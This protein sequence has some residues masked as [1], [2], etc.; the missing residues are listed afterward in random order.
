[1]RVLVTRPEI[2]ARQ[3]A[4]KLQALGH[5]PALLPLARA[6]HNADVA[7]TALSRPHSA[8]AITSAEAVRVLKNLEEQL[9][10][11]LHET[12]YAVGD[13]TAKAAVAAGFRNV[14]AG[15]GTG[16]DLATQIDAPA[17]APLL[18]LAGK[19]RSTG[20][21]EGLHQRQLPF[22]IAE[23]YEMVPIT[24]DTDTVSRSLLEPPVDAVLLYS[25][26]SA[27]RFFDVAAPHL[28]HLTSL[29]I[30]CLSPKMA[31]VAPPR[32]HTNIRI[33]DH[34]EEDG[35]LALL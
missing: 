11:H 2:A 29:R 34:P 21:E 3:T 12:L 7:K 22:T 6:V 8:L 28:E 10:P 20:F 16:A 17:E 18:Y 5:E 35:L 1:M 13:A 33:A 27:R 9:A 31:E 19:P 25:R 32:F 15:P 30:L 23:I 4:A 26:E 14:H 24:Y